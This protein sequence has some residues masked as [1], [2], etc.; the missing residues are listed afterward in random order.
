MD[1]LDGGHGGR[2]VGAGPRRFGSVLARARA[3]GVEEQPA[4]ESGDQSRPEAHALQ[5][6]IAWATSRLQRAR[7]FRPLKTFPVSFSTL[8]GQSP[9]V[10]WW[11]DRDPRPFI[12]ADSGPGACWMSQRFAAFPRI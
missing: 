6:S 3:S 2:L 8:S 4:N 1:W 7:L 5:E 9:V 10:C 11:L 12:M